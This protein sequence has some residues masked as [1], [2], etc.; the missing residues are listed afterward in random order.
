MTGRLGMEGGRVGVEMEGGVGWIWTVARPKMGRWRFPKMNR[1]VSQN[2]WGFYVSR[3]MRALLCQLSLAIGK[4]P[5]WMLK[6]WT[7]QKE[8]GDW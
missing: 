1:G 8:V 5:F 7:N 2:G 6:I 3:P 4:L